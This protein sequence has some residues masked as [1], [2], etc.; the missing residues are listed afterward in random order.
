MPPLTDLYRR[1]PAWRGHLFDALLAATMVAL[2]N[3]APGKPG[4][5]VAAQP[6]AFALWWT[7]TA[8]LVLGLAVRRRWPVAALVLAGVGAAAHQVVAEACHRRVPFPTL[9]D[10][11]V[12]VVLYTVASRSRSRWRSLA[13]LAATAGVEVAVSL[14]SALAAGARPAASA[15]DSAVGDDPVVDPGSV[16][17]GDRMTEVKPAGG[18][19]RMLAFVQQQIVELAGIVLLALA[20]AYALGEAARSRHAHLRIL[21]ERAADLER[22]QQQRLALAAA[23]ER[24]RIGRDLHDVLAHSLS[25]MVAQAQAA[26][27]AQHRH[28]QRATRAVR[29]VIT[30]GRDSLAELRRLV[31][32]FGAEPD[33]RDALAPIGVAALPTLIERVRAAGVPVLYTHDG[34]PVDL[35]PGVDVSVYRIVQEALTNTL[36]HAGAGARAR[37]RLATGP[38]YVDVEVS[39]DGTGPSADPDAGPGNGL[40]GIAERV[41]LL[42]GT[43]TVGP[44]PDGG[45]LVRTRLPVPAGTP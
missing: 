3:P 2:S 19:E 11:A 28:P 45:F 24:A 29:E 41:G 27:A 36:K 31:G 1:L 32:T 23:A 25:V 33:A 9:I 38:A 37:V 12:L 8:L 13:A 21:E 22:E 10:L 7:F 15:G 30:V 20:L 34:A 26:L 16:L 44:N 18:D 35:P 43:L 40:R 39:D 4:Q 6:W 5:A 42:G 17:G 14:G